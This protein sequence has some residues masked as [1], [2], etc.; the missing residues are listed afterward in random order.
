MKQSGRKINL[1]LACG[2]L[3]LC[4]AGCGQKEETVEELVI[5]NNQ[6]DDGIYSFVEC[7]KSDVILTDSVTVEYVQAS[8]QNISIETGGRRIIRVC[9]K[10]G[11]QV[12]AGDILLKLDDDNLEEQIENLSYQIKS[13]ELKLE[14]IEKQKELSLNETYVNYVFGSGLNSEDQLKAYEKSVEEVEQNFRYQ[15]E[16]CEDSLEFDRRKL[17]ELKTKLSQARVYAQ[18]DGLVYKIEDNL[19]G[20][21]TRKD[22]VIMTIVDESEGYFRAKDSQIFSDTTREASYEMNVSYGNASGDYEL[23]PSRVDQWGE[24]QYFDILS[25]PESA[26]LEVGTKG[27]ITVAVDEIKDTLSLPSNCVHMAGDDYYVY[28]LDDQGMRTIRYI[29]IGLVG[30]KTTQITK[31]LTEGEMVVRK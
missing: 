6:K 27:T 7:T 3:L 30:D 18:M 10:E 26:I 28:V 2:F 29:E 16:D 5:V 13:N 22:Q 4:F 8:E 12:K 1:I 31:G 24:E 21:I 9:V 11:D 23:I 14:Y 25:S 17:T 20:S 19:E 15:R